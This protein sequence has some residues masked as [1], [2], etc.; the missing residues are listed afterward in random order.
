MGV[1]QIHVGVFV[2]VPTPVA[3]VFAVAVVLDHIVFAVAISHID[4]AIGT[5]RGFGWAKRIAGVVDAHGLWVP[6]VKQDA[7]VQRHLGHAAVVA[8][9][10]AVAIKRPSAIGD[11]Q[12][13]FVTFVHQA[14]AMTAGEDGSPGIQQFAG[15]VKDEDVV[16]GVVADHEQPTAFV[17]HH[18]VTVEKRRSERADLGPIA[19]H[20]IAI[21]AVP[22]DLG[23]ILG[24][25]CGQ[26]ASGSGRGESGDGG[27]LQEVAAGCLGQDSR[28]SRSDGMRAK[29]G[30]ARE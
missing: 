1:L 12:E 15:F 24:R 16:V 21:I 9:R 6:D 14:E 3:N 17:L 18:F 22:D 25:S 11:Q 19:N 2:V 26:R 5:D 28:S 27:F 20:A 29:R 4:V 23:L 13:F 10:F 8:D 30:P 7:A